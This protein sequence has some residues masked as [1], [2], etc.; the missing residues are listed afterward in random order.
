MMTDAASLCQ[1]LCG[2]RS[3]LFWNLHWKANSIL[4]HERKK[5]EKRKIGYSLCIKGVQGPTNQRPG[6][7][8]A[9]REMKILHC[10]HVKERLQKKRHPFILYNEQDNEDTNNSKDLKNMKNLSFK[11]TGKP[12]ASNIF[13]FI[14]SMGTA[15]RLK[16]ERKLELLAIFILE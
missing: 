11:V 10:E 1:I 7:V 12:A 9:T 5:L 3:R 2:V 16:V 14:N 15:R 6:F 4:Q 13:V 8:E